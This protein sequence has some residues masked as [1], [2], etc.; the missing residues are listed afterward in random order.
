M[1]NRGRKQDYQSYVKE[2]KKLKE[3]M[4]KSGRQMAQRMYTKR[5]WEQYHLALSND[6]Q[7]EINR[8]QRKIKG[9]IN[10]DL[11][12]RQQWEYSSKQAKAMSKVIK[13]QTGKTPLV[14]DIRSGKVQIDWKKLQEEEERLIELG[15]DEEDAR[16]KIHSE[17]WGS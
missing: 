5:E 14:K 3:T 6:R 15:E 1:E 16:K 11:A 17:Y 9:N 10:R 4:N 8:G 12:K 2:Y 7:K 13:K